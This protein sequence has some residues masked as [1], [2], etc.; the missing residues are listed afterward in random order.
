MSN[1]PLNLR[2][3]SYITLDGRDIVDPTGNLK[4]AADFISNTAVVN[5]LAQEYV[6][7]VLKRCQ[8]EN[9]ICI[10]GTKYAYCLEVAY[11]DKICSFL[12]SS[13]YRIGFSNTNMIEFDICNII[14]ASHV[15]N[16][17][18][19]ELLDF[20]ARMDTIPYDNDNVWTHDTYV[21]LQA[22]CFGYCVA[23][24]INKCRTQCEYNLPSLIINIIDTLFNNFGLK[25]SAVHNCSYFTIRGISDSE[26]STITNQSDVNNPIT[27]SLAKP[28]VPE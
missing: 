1:I 8:L 18:N 24:H 17:S 13:A 12:P 21:R 3:L 6:K 15:K 26:T 4:R 7:N 28:L 27:I 19:N 2:Q 10:W 9:V 14:A 22:L 11:A 5:K 23:K 25:A 16:P 20:I